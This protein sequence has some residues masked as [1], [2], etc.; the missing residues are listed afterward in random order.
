MKLLFELSGEHPTLPF[1]ELETVGTIQE[2]R[3]QVAVAECP[4]PAAVRRLALTHVVL[5][6]LG[7]CRPDRA[8]IIDLIRDLSLSPDGPFA[9]RVKKVHG[10]EMVESETSL[11]RFIGSRIPGRVSLKNPSVEYRAIFSEDTCFFGRVLCRIDRGSFDSRNP[12]RRPFFHP[13][14]IMPR[15]ARA[16]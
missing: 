2:T 15:M 10:A 5:E 6:Y 3:L 13:G 14:V 9:V 8:A 11:E 16:I 12:M 1:A 4:H 7:E